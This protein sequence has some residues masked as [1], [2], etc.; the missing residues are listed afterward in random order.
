MRSHPEYASTLKQVWLFSELTPKQK[1][2]LNIPSTDQGIDLVAQT[3]TGDYWA[4][5]CKYLDN[6]N[7]RLSH[8]SGG[9]T[10]L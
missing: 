6:E 8:D 9:V 7:K 10:C 2:E 5:Q 4:I 3:T 1:M